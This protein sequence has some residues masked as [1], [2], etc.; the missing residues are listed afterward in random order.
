M[1]PTGPENVERAVA[2]ATD[3][4]RLER[5][6][7]GLRPRMAASPP[8]DAAAHTHALEELYRRLWQERIGAF[9]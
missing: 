7:A 9:A 5:L 2:L 6:R 8:T 4:D 1:A 3:L